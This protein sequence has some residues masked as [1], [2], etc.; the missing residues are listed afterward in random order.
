MKY[1]QEAMVMYLLHAGVDI[2]ER[3][4]GGYTVLA[5]AISNKQNDLVQ[6]LVNEGADITT[7]GGVS[8]FE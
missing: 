4:K 2:N 8:I 1:N 3:D 5:Y 7:P 6:L